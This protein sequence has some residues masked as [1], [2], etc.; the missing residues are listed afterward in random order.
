[1]ATL[2][3]S[4]DFGSHKLQSS[5]ARAAKT[6]KGTGPR[7]ELGKERSKHN[8]RTHGIFSNVVVLESESQAEFD[9]LLNGLRKDFQP[10]GMLEDGLVEILADTWWHRRRLL[11]AERAEIEANSRFREWDDQ[12]RQLQ[13][14]GTLPAVSPMA[15]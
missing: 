15:V 1:M 2:E 7:T 14:A 5:T 10:V 3:S 11:V 4:N 9:T 13:E 6:R 12:Q 8:A